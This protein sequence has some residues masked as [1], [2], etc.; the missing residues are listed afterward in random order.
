MPAKELVRGEGWLLEAASWMKAHPQFMLLNVEATS[1]N[2]GHPPAGLVV[3]VDLLGKS[4]GEF[5]A[6]PQNG[7]F[8]MAASTV[9]NMRE[10]I[11]FSET[12][13]DLSLHMPILTST[14]HGD[15]T[16]GPFIPQT[17][18]R[19]FLFDTSSSE[20]LRK[21]LIETFGAEAFIES[22]SKEFKVCFS[23][24]FG[25]EIPDDIVRNCLE[26]FKSLILSENFSMG[27][28]NASTNL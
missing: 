21:S 19:F 17:Y 9:I 25:A 12:S 2:G 27:V 15:G 16:F 26:G 11:P 7:T 13:N 1:N 6:D 24:R 4:N 10:G 22:M 5:K 23:P 8:H 14:T 18:N 3:R 20:E 28:Y